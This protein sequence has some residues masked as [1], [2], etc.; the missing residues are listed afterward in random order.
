MQM[1]GSSLRVYGPPRG[2]LAAQGQRYKYRAVPPKMLE[3]IITDCCFHLHIHTH[4]H[5]PHRQGEITTRYQHHRYSTLLYSIHSPVQ[6]SNRYPIDLHLTLPP[7][8]SPARRTRSTCST[9]A[10]RQRNT[11]PN[12]PHLKFDPFERVFDELN[13]DRL[14][15]MTWAREMRNYARVRSFSHTL[16]KDNPDGTPADPENHGNDQEKTFMIT[17]MHTHVSWTPR[18]V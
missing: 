8:T 4:P 9:M 1:K 2:G 5:S 18:P 7:F 3:G 11:P 14:N 12:N 17:I 6:Q 15:Y 16:P 13:I 10:A